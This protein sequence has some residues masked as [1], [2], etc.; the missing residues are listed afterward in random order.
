MT[1][2]PDSFI[3]RLTGDTHRNTDIINQNNTHNNNNSNTNA[4][5]GG[6]GNPSSINNTNDNDNISG[7]K[8]PV[9]GQGQAEHPDIVPKKKHTNPSAAS[10]HAKASFVY[11]DPFS[12]PSNPLLKNCSTQ[13]V[14][15]SRKKYQTKNSNTNSSTSS[16]SSSRNSSSSTAASSSIHSSGSYVAA[17]HKPANRVDDAVNSIA[18]EM[19]SSQSIDRL[20]VQY[21]GGSQPEFSQTAKHI[22][23][24]YPVIPNDDERYKL[25][26]QK[27]TSLE[28][29]LQCIICHDAPKQIVLMPC[30]HLSV[31]SECEIH[32]TLPETAICPVCRTA[33]KETLKV[34]PI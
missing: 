34:F 9:L 11:C 2:D 10:S 3:A 22:L 23:T 26:L 19:L 12:K 5:N 1:E 25:C 32:Y 13:S 20:A 14:S 18:T 15:S 31:C 16:S 27:I 8:R 6:T 21:T 4:T 28:C 30:K 24:K 29:Q 17:K 33:V 7:S